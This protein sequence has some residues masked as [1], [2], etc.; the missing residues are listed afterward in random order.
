MLK[1]KRSKHNREQSKHDHEDNL[2]H[3]SP[4]TMMG[5]DRQSTKM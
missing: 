1:K 5:I 4:D 2:I 3:Q